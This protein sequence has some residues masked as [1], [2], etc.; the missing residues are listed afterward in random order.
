ML[1]Q[2]KLRDGF[3]SSDARLLRMMDSS[4]RTGTFKPSPIQ[5]DRASHLCFESPEAVD[6]VEEIDQGVV[7]QSDNSARQDG[8][9]KL[10][11]KLQDAHVAALGQIDPKVGV[12]RSWALPGGGRRSC[13]RPRKEFLLRGECGEAE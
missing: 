3:G 10:F 5:L 11:T 13:R 1:Q 2:G 6:P 7:T 8:G 4:G 12:E 9:T